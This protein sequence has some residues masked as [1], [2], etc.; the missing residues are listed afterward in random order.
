MWNAVSASGGTRL[1][2][3]EET[4]IEFSKAYLEILDWIEV[5]EIEN[6]GEISLTYTQVNHK[7]LNQRRTNK[8]KGS[9]DIDI[10]VIK[11][12]KIVTDLGQQILKTAID[13]KKAYIFMLHLSDYGRMYF[14]SKLSAASTALT[15]VNTICGIS[16][17]LMFTSSILDFDPIQQLNNWWAYFFEPVAI[18]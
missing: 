9:Y 12:A 14:Y 5:G 7:T 13:E 15:G 2:V 8:K 6:I 18:I 1:Y 10:V 11:L 3:T 16:F 17:S 4:P